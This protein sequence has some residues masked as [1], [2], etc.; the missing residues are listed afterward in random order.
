MIKLATKSKAKAGCESP[1]QPGS[2]D[3]ILTFVMEMRRPSA[4]VLPHEIVAEILDFARNPIQEVQKA[5]AG[6]PSRLVDLITNNERKAGL[7]RVAS[8]TIT[9]CI[10]G[11][12]VTSFNTNYASYISARNAALRTPPQSERLRARSN[13]KSG[14]QRHRSN[15]SGNFS[16]SSRRSSLPWD[17]RDRS[18]RSQ[19][20]QRYDMIAERTERAGG[21][22][23]PWETTQAG[24]P[25]NTN[26]PHSS[27]NQRPDNPRWHPPISQPLSAN[28]NFVTNVRAN[29]NTNT[30]TASPAA[31]SL[32]GSFG[33]S[34]L[35]LCGSELSAMQKREALL[36]SGAVVAVTGLLRQSTARLQLAL[37][38]NLP[39]TIP[40][41]ST[42]PFL[43]AASAVLS[44]T[45]LTTDVQIQLLA[46]SPTPSQSQSQ[47]GGAGGRTGGTA[48][49][50]SGPGAGTGPGSSCGVGS[51]V[52]AQ[53]QEAGTVSAYFELLACLDRCNDDYTY[54]RSTATPTTTAVAI[55]FLRIL[56]AHSLGS[57]TYD[58][59]GEIPHARQ[60]RQQVVESGLLAL[61]LREVAGELTGQL[62]GQ[63]TEQ[64]N[65][66][67]TLRS[68]QLV[69]S[70]FSTSSSRSAATGVSTKPAP[71]N[72]RKSTNKSKS[73]GG[74]GSSSSIPRGR[75]QEQL[76]EER[77]E[78]RHELR[79]LTALL[80]ANLA[81]DEAHHAVLMTGTDGDGD[82]D[83]SA[84]RGNPG[85]SRGVMPVV[86]RSI[87]ASPRDPR[88]QK[89]CATVLY[90]LALS[91]PD[92]VKTM[93]RYGTH[94]VLER[95][96]RCHVLGATP[97]AQTQLK[98]LLTSLLTE[99]KQWKGYTS[100]DLDLGLDQNVSADVDRPLD[101]Q[102]QEEMVVVMEEEEVVEDTQR[103]D[104]E[105][106]QQQ[107]SLADT[108]DRKT[109]FKS[110]RFSSLDSCSTDLF[111]SLDTLHL[112]DHPQLNDGL[113]TALQ[114]H[115]QLEVQRNASDLDWGNFQLHERDSDFEYVYCEEE[116]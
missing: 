23:L 102:Q 30:N 61:L 10:L 19:R 24:M 116:V 105:V 114:P 33:L 35:S 18:N 90:N 99:L 113:D 78:Q 40:V 107:Q 53:V 89:N 13:P 51:V 100:V 92:C 93:R 86:L 15:F 94:R 104:E 68:R 81:C 6:A 50:R 16:S 42:A 109:S 9:E 112:E 12:P 2:D 64:T 85:A 76:E 47:N 48:G 4:P 44:L 110:S 38:K 60:V 43:S 67:L 63:P 106:Q 29:T 25:S 22:P 91:S 65:G 37:T 57:L 54:Q 75:R 111:D 66:Q 1:P 41:E 39:T 83:D 31:S 14:A 56:I 28:D 84:S 62:T 72:K 46:P 77:E 7:Q 97:G 52:H 20:P 27:N 80:L 98:V 87:S 95:A 79:Y 45:T 32:A 82:G 5:L 74:G 96:Y 34:G 73:T 58:A 55:S 3:A 71:L 108:A 17:F 21:R 88:V 11:M 115:A 103:Q 59:R 101:Q 26:A 49:A 36:W 8:N 70:S 69:L